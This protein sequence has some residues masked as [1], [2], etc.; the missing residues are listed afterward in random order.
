[1]LELPDE[2]LAF[3]ERRQ[4]SGGHGRALLICK[5]RAKRRL[6]ARRAYEEGWSVR[7]TER[8][9]READGDRAGAARPTEGIVIH[10]DLADLLAAAEDALAAALALDVRVRARGGRCRVEF[11]L[12]DPSEAVELAARLARRAAV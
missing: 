12:A 5:E 11:D 4:L 10:P 2:V 8:R 6:L 1:M 7:E 3:V 9:A